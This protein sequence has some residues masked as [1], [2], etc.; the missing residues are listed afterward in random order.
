MVGIENLESVFEKFTG[1]AGPLAE[2]INTAISSLNPYQKQ[3]YM[4]YAVQNPEIAIAAAQR[5]KDFLEAIQRNTNPTVSSSFLDAPGTSI[6]LFPVGGGQTTPLTATPVSVEEGIAGL[7]P[8]VAASGGGDGFNPFDISPRDSSIRTPDQY[9]PYAY[10]QAM[11]NTEKFGQTVGPNPDLYYAPQTGIEQLLSKIPTPF[12]FIRKG[13]DALGDKLPV[14]EAAI[15]QNELLGQGI[16]LDNIGR[17]V[18]DNYNTPEGIM[19]GYNPV[20]GGLLNYITDGK[21]G[22]PTQYGLANAVAERQENIRNTLQDKYGLSDQQIDEVLD[23]I[24]KNKTYTGPLGFDPKRQKTTELFQQLYNVGQFGI[25]NK[26]ALERLNL[27]SKQ[28]REDKRKSDPTFI[29]QQKQEKDAKDKRDIQQKV[30]EA[31]AE[32]KKAAAAR[33]SAVAQE[34]ANREAAREAGRQA[35]AK[36]AAD[37]KAARIREEG[38][39]KSIKEAAKKAAAKKA[40]ENRDGQGDRSGGRSSGSGESDYGGFCFDPNTPI[41]MADGSEKKI[42]DIQLGDDTKGGEVTGV[43]QFKATDEIHDYKGVTVAGS[44]YVKEDG[45]FIMVKDSLLSVKIDKIP[46]VYSLDTTGR[47]I[48]INDIEFA[49][50]NGDGIAKGFLEN[51]GVDLA[52]FDKEVLRQVEHRLI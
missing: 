41:Q 8:Q 16:K 42:K 6:G 48:F 7:Y 49:D 26:N 24:E 30:A 22:E 18:T 15:F 4:N 12:N 29:E 3:Q 11:R 9:S 21:Y 2:N 44:H 34:A 20:S 25:L 13:L 27:I 39:Q 45:K 35:A 37:E 1:K 38:I 14:N 47:R 17:I 19:A 32:A 43:F 52:G 46:V 23:E 28:Q 51:A 10:N 31:E 50:Y 40:A 33:A 5:N 36:K